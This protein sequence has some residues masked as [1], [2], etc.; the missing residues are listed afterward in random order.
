MSYSFI[1]IA[2]DKGE[3]NKHYYYG[4]NSSKN[5]QGIRVLGKKLGETD[6]SDTREGKKEKS[7]GIE[8]LET[9]RYMYDRNIEEF[10]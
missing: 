8:R 4:N 10:L 7:D 9:C 2:C 1:I 6:L 5:V 3:K